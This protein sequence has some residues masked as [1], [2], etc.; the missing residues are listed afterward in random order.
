[1]QSISTYTPSLF[2]R[3]S[4]FPLTSHLSHTHTPIASLIHSPNGGRR[5]HGYGA[6]GQALEGGCSLYECSLC[7]ACDLVDRSLCR[8]AGRAIGH[9]TRRLC[10][11]GHVERSFG[12]AVGQVE[13]HVERSLGPAVGKPLAK[14]GA[15][16]RTLPWAPALLDTPTLDNLENDEAKSMPTTSKKPRTKKLAPPAPGQEGQIFKAMSKAKPSSS[17]AKQGSGKM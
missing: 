4:Y 11:F 3:I 2:S 15:A 6:F 1:M 5:K 10:A 13:R 12:Q 16:K 14:P 17:E 7:R 8:A 9:I